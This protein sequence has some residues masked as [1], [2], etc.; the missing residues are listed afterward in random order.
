MKIDSKRLLVVQLAKNN[1]LTF[2]LPVLIYTKLFLDILNQLA[3]SIQDFGEVYRV[4]K[5]M[6]IP[7]NGTQAGYMMLNL[8]TKLIYRPFFYGDKPSHDID[9]KLM[10]PQ[11]VRF[12]LALYFFGADTENRT[13]HDDFVRNFITLNIDK[14]MEIRHGVK[15]FFNDL[16]ETAILDSGNKKLLANLEAIKSI[17]ALASSYGPNLDRS[18][19][20]PFN[21][22]GID[23][24]PEVV[25]KFTNQFLEN[26][27]VN[28]SK[29]LVE[30]VSQLVKAEDEQSADLM[31]DFSL[32]LPKFIMDTYSVIESRVADCI[33][34]YIKCSTIAKIK[35]RDI[36]K[37]LL[38]GHPQLVEVPTGLAR[39]IAK[40][41][42]RPKLE[43]DEILL[44]IEI[45]DIRPT[46]WKLNCTFQ[47]NDQPVTLAVYERAHSTF[48]E[49]EVVEH[50]LKRLTSTLR[51]VIGEQNLLAAQ[52]ADFESQ[53]TKLKKSAS[54][55]DRKFLGSFTC[56]GT[57][58]LKRDLGLCY[59]YLHLRDEL[60]Q[61]RQA[62]DFGPI[63]SV[64]DIN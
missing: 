18:S 50:Y 35:P 58:Y 1:L 13:P 26:Q 36:A 19:L 11:A 47:L 5:E 46:L 3:K 49:A 23:P 45:T 53:L 54:R 20:P 10:V 38:P 30:K 61:H 55:N 41:E 22:Y 63:K 16:N 2:A 60:K 43:V 64:E 27:K 24:N 44:E 25:Q 59:Q 8:H 34:K 28:I 33:N 31:K 52:S 37:H 4:L 48:S 7:A 62:F 42:E 12:G 29:A 56:D 32:M 9:F 39:I 6:I 51:K 57:T 15:L 17:T 21:H 14:S 40:G